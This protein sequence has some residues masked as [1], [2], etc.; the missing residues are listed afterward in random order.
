[1]LFP[2]GQRRPQLD[3]RLLLCGTLETCVDHVTCL[4]HPISWS[5]VLHAGVG[6]SL[7]G[8]PWFLM[9]L[10][11]FTLLNATLHFPEF[12]LDMKSRSPLLLS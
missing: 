11:G 7:G 1:M 4:H 9:A 3:L 5:L 2:V 12:S 10:L 6:V 8:G